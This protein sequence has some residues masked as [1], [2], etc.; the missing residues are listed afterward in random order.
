MEE[1]KGLKYKFTSKNMQK[2]LTNISLPSIKVFFLTKMGLAPRCRFIN[3][4]ESTNISM[5]LIKLRSQILNL[6][7]WCVIKMLW[8]NVLCMYVI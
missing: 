6:S 5:Y 7:M 1:I 4:V 3:V 8:K 2:K